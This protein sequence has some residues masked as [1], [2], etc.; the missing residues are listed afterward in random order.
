VPVD[1]GLPKAREIL[2]PGTRSVSVRPSEV[3]TV[4]FTAD[5]RWLIGF[6]EDGV[7]RESRL[8]VAPAASLA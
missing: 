2:G 1:G 8:V 6:L 7:R 4:L 5:G 3:P